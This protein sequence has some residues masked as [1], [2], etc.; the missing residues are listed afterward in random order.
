MPPEANK[1][2]PTDLLAAD[3]AQL[4]KKSA[5][6]AEGEGAFAVQALRPSLRGS[7]SKVPDDV[8]TDEDIAAI[9]DRVARGHRGFTGVRERIPEKVEM[10]RLTLAIP[11]ATGQDLAEKAAKARVT[12]TYLLLKALKAAGF[13]VP[14]AG[15]IPDGRA[16]R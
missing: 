15:L 3:F 4:A 9:A 6:P 5:K 2:D 16:R 14:E 11:A 7:L 1:A 10:E 13:V 12:K 8:D